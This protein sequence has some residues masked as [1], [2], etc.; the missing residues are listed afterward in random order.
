[1]AA[2][3]TSSASST[4][5]LA[6]LCFT[7]SGCTPPSASVGTGRLQQLRGPVCVFV[8]TVYTFSCEFF[9]LR[10]KP[11]S[12]AV[13]AY[14]GRGLRVCLVAF[15]WML[16]CGVCALFDGVGQQTFFPETNGC[17]LL[18]VPLV[19]IEKVTE[20]ANKAEKGTMRIPDED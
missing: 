16:Q 11:A 15:T 6:S 1:M 8:F 10:N 17:R 7:G 20:D 9:S 12:F 3:Y 2:T 19:L 14:A 4:L 5:A 18:C 13:Y